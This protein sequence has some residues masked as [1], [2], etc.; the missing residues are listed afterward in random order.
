[1]PMRD[2]QQRQRAAR[3]HH[4]PRP[5]ADTARLGPDPDHIADEACDD[6]KRQGTVQPGRQLIDRG[7]G[8]R[9]I[10]DAQSEHRGIAEP[11]GEPGQE[12]DLGDVDRIQ[13]PGRIDPVAHRA[14][15]EDAGADIVADRIAG[16]GGERVDAVGDVRYADRPHREQI[17]E[18]QREIAGGRR[19]ALAS[20][21]WRGSVSLIAS[22]TS[23]V[24][25]PRSMWI[26]HVARDPDDRHAD[27][28]ARSYAG[29]ASGAETNRPAYCFQHL[30]LELRS[31]SI[32]MR[33]QRDLAAERT[34]PTFRCSPRSDW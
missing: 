20:T 24:S 34:S 25:M 6:R 33:L 14:A 7:R 8:L 10:G 30:D 5:A 26:E 12:A 1:M 31:R 18:G 9:V 19:T 29:L 11:E 16:E 27:H 15:G 32:S 23:S 2:L 4:G 3:Q 13:P 21:I 28:N 17:V 22:I